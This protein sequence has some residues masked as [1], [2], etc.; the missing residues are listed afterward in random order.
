[1]ADPCDCCPFQEAIDLLSKRHAMTIVWL[2]Q[3]QS[4]RRF[5]EIKRALELNPVTLSQRLSE[6]E[7]GGVIARTTYPEA[8]PRVEYS[9]TPKGQDLL[10]LMEQMNDWARKYQ[11]TVQPDQPNSDGV[12]EA[13]ATAA[14]SSGKAGKPRNSP[15]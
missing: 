10:P 12:T 14:S 15:A 5:N 3:Q 13:V 1:M 2:L 6:L 8:P 7:T 11:V 9:L 4:P